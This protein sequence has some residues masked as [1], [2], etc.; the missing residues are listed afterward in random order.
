VQRRGRRNLAW[1]RP[2]MFANSGRANNAKRREMR[3]DR[4]LVY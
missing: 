4:S 3:S 2:T 1:K